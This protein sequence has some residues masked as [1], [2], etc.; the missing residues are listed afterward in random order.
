MG[1]VGPDAAFDKKS[2]DATFDTSERRL[3]QRLSKNKITI[4][5]DAMH[6]LRRFAQ[7]L[8]S[9]TICWKP[10]GVQ[11]EQ[12]ARWF[13]VFE[14]NFLQGSGHDII[15]G[16]F[17]KGRRFKSIAMAW[18]AERARARF[19]TSTCRTRSGNLSFL[20]EKVRC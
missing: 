20:E 18:A 14:L 13:P 1:S 5:L 15:L 12:S 6:F 4:K 7:D 8:R 19:L 11:E 16:F 2:H 10:L 3:Y 9:K 17:K